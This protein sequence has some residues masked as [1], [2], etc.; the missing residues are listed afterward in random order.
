MAVYKFCPTHSFCEYYGETS[1]IKWAIKAPKIEIVQ[2]EL[3]STNQPSQK[4]SSFTRM[5]ICTQFF[6][7]LP[8][9]LLAQLV[10]RCNG[11]AEV[12]GSNPVRA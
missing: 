6:D 10:E 2:A 4:E 8:V 12:M 9:G 1:A 3:S 11:I 7:Q 5:F